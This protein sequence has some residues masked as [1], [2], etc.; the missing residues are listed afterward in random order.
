MGGARG[1]KGNGS[2]RSGSL[3]CAEKP[4]P[5]CREMERHDWTVLVDKRV[6][7]VE[8]IIFSSKS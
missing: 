4:K 5:A 1:G 3:L 6:F 7:S 2:V 8:I